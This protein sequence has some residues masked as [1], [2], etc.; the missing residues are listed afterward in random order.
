[1]GYDCSNC[2]SICCQNE[3][4]LPL[5]EF[6]EDLL[7]E[8]FP[9]LNPLIM[10]EAKRNSW[11]LRSNSCILLDDSGKCSIQSELGYDKKPLVCKI[12]PLI[13]WKCTENIVLAYVYPCKGMKWVNLSNNDDFDYLKIKENYFKYKN[14]F[15]MILADQIDEEN[16]FTYVTKE[17]LLNSNEL[18]NKI[19]DNNYNLIDLIYNYQ[20][21]WKS[22]NLI[23]LPLLILNNLNK[24]DLEREDFINLWKKY[25][26]SLFTWLFF[27]PFFLVV[28]KE[29]SL[30]VCLLGLF[31]GKNLLYHQL[32]VL[33]NFQLNPAKISII[34]ESI[35]WGIVEIVT[36]KWWMNLNTFIN[37]YH[38]ENENKLKKEVEKLK[39]YLPLGD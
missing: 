37:R 6:E 24:F 5:L 23:S 31:W 13:Y 29:I 12:Y 27:N 4:K 8:T 21:S 3:Y 28:E 20:T 36:P 32:S 7:I 14:Y 11:L 17:D 1:M 35:A 38:S 33:E 26:I 30:L 18:M 39:K 2:K 34:F 22:F 10:K 9:Y 15:K 16:I 25:E 19:K